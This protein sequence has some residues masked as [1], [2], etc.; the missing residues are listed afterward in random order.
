MDREQYI[1]M[2]AQ[3]IYDAEE[4]MKYYYYKRMGYEAS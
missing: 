1:S 4:Q 2:I 3:E